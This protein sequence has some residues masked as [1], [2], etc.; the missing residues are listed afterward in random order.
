MQTLIRKMMVLFVLAG[1]LA[2]CTDESEQPITTWQELA[3]FP[4]TPRA[5]AV[6]FSIGDSAYICLGRSGSRSGC[7]KD[8]WKYDSRTDSWHQL[9]D[10]PGAARVKA[11]G[12]AIG[13]KGYVGMG[14]DGDLTGPFFDDFWEYDPATDNWT[15]KASYPGPARNDLAYAVVA[16]KLYVTMGFDGTRLQYDTYAY[17]PETDAWTKLAPCPDKY[18]NAIAF[19]IGP[20][21]YV[22]AGVRGI[23]QRTFFRYDTRSNNW[24]RKA[25]L[26]EG[27]MLSNSLTVEGKG[28]LLLGRFWNGSL[29]GGRFLSDV[30]EYNPAT[31]SWTKRGDFPGGARQN[32]V[33][34]CIGDKGYVAL[35]EDDSER[36][37]DV[38]CFK[39]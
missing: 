27:R 4:G 39:P 34:F 26:P 17:D 2:A 24:T 28:Y 6:A 18:F 30:V 15:R 5:S 37:S 32:A 11:V 38:W 33:V 8:C 7:L 13:Q 1:C 36:K 22:G 16:G 29:N 31:D 25:K 10:F 21:F 20:F 3:P 9:R 12:V 19:G 23:N 35:G 14:C